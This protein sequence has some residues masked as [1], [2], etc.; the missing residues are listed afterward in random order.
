MNDE[1]VKQ[2]LVEMFQSEKILDL[3]ALK[4][5]IGSRSRMTVFRKLKAIG[6]YTSYSHDGKFYTLHSIPCFDCY[7]LWHYR[8]V[9]FSRYGNLIET[10]VEMVKEA[11]AG[12][13]ASELERL[14]FVFV[15]NALGKLFVSGRLWREQI[16]NQYLYLSLS[17]SSYQLAERKRRI[18]LSAGKEVEIVGLATEEFGDQINLFLSVLNEKQRRLYVGLE[19][20]KYGH[21]GDVRMARTTG[22]NVKTIARGRRELMSRSIDMTRIRRQGAGRPPLK[23]TKS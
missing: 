1:I 22:V 2:K 9:H 4:D 19:S 17:G 18:T 14:L 5:I 15:H 21:G 11:E 8:G 13:F 6:Y 3:P 12:Y 23:K 20:L 7:G 16:G 10:L